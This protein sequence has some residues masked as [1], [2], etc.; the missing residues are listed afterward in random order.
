MNYPFI[1]EIIICVIIGYFLGSV[2]FG[3]I[4][5]KDAGIDIRQSGSGNTGTTNALRT[6]GKKAA[7]LTFLGDFLKAFIPAILVRIISYKVIGTGA[8]M[9]YLLSLITGLSTVLGHNFP[10][11]MHF[12][13]GKG[14]AVTSGVTVAIAY[15]HWPYILIALAVFIIIV[16]ITRYVSV[17]SLS[18]PAWAL[19]VYALIYER[20]NTYFSYILII[21]FLFTVLAVIMHRENIKRLI[22]GTE[23][24]LFFKK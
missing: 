22:N 18:V 12:K 21:S 16:V 13:G 10:V 24:K 5:G 20:D 15:E 2:S 7:L 4:I 6:L 19:P 23:N 8:D 17:G 1:V 9:A 11:W 14:I 3:Y